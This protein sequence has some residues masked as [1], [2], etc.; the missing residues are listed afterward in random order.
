MARSH[1]AGRRAIAAAAATLGVVSMTAGLA[2]G[3]YGQYAHFP[4]NNPPLADQL[5]R[6]LSLCGAVVPPPPN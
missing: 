4:N 2:L 1:P 3:F 6:R 5:V